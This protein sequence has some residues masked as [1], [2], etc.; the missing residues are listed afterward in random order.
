MDG[1]I[2]KII[3]ASSLIR[4]EKFRA[5]FHVFIKRASQQHLLVV[6]TETPYEIN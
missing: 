1:Y 6:W 4:L 2:I 5:K 3:K